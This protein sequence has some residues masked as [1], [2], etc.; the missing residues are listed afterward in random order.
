MKLWILEPITK[1]NG[2]AWEPWYD[3][4]FGMI[5]RAETED[6]ARSIANNNGGDEN[7]DGR[8]PW[9]DNKQSSCVEL[10]SDGPEEMILQDFASA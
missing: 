10:S 3:K 6:A 9:L 2:S 7:R 8:T 5:V 1:G 4:A